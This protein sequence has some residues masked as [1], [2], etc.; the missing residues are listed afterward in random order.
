[1]SKNVFDDLDAFNYEFCEKS[2]EEMY[3]EML[4]KQE[5]KRD[6]FIYIY[7]GF[8]GIAPSLT[9]A[10][11]SLFFWLAYRCNVNTGRVIVQSITLKD[12]LKELGITVGTYYKALTILKEKELIKGG[13]ATYYV[14]PYY[15]WK[16]TADMRAKFLRIYPGLKG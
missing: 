11:M 14:N 4:G 5:L 13:N 12:C 15:A 8:L 1:M 10:A 3:E 7:G 9:A 16:G 2:V 6:E